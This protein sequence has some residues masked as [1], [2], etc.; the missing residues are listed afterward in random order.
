MRAQ[1][2]YPHDL[3]PS[4]LGV[5]RETKNQ[6]NNAKTERRANMKAKKLLS[7]LCSM[8]MVA[9]M[10]MAAF[11]SGQDFT[12]AN[13]KAEANV[14]LNATLAEGTPTYLVNV[15]WTS[16]TFNYTPGDKTWDTTAHTWNTT[17][18]TWDNEGKAT[19][20]AVNHSSEQ[21]TISATYAPKTPGQYES[22]NPHNGVT[23]TFDNFSTGTLAAGS[24]DNT[25]EGTLGNNR[26]EATLTV[27]GD[28][29]EAIASDVVGTIT[30]TLGAGAEE[31]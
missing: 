6:R 31:P 14:T 24:G 1:G 22:G 28:P 19:V 11:A 15:S 17:K 12:G 18:G 25:G 30:I 26:V 4:A 9:S 2:N 10:G 7:I 8:A 20:T 21:V 29:I 27:S 13:G 3:C 16:M 23:V 5:N